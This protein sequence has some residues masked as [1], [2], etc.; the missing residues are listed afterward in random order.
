MEKVGYLGPE[1]SYSHIA[2]RTLRP[3]AELCG[4]SSF[5][6]AVEALCAGVCSAVALPIENSLNGS[7]TQVTDLLQYTENIIAFEECV[8]KIDHRLAVLK[9]ADYSGISRI[10]SHEQALAQCGQFI[11]KSFPNAELIATQS[12][13]AGLKMLKS[14]ADACIVGAHTDCPN[15]VLSKENIADEKNNLTHFLLIK[16][17]AAA[18]LSASRRVYF[19]A[20][21]NHAAG[22]LVGLLSVIKNGGL[23]MT[24]IQSRPIKDKA[25]EYRFFV[26]VEGDISDSHIKNVLAEIKSA[27]NSFKILGAY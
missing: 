13:A 15:V 11:F 10:Y 6:L 24:K 4:Y 23:N 19:S 16:R 2:A 14:A 26:E 8:V 18:D 5:R 17:G 27:A 9:G 1:G 20:T 3:N 22:A 7:V 25:G 12:T 21:C